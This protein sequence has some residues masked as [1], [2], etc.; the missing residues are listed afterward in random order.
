MNTTMNKLYDELV[1]LGAKAAIEK[2]TPAM[3]E[4]IDIV[5]ADTSL[6]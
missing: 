4:Q 6:E 5:M 2:Y 1:V 3:Q